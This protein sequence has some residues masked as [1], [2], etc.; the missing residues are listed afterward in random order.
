MTTEKATG[1]FTISNTTAS[2]IL[3]FTSSASFARARNG[4]LDQD[5]Y[6]REFNGTGQAY[7]DVGYD[8]SLVGM[9]G[10]QYTPQRLLPADQLFQIGGPTTVRGYKVDALGGDDGVYVNGEVHPRL[11]SLVQGLDVFSFFDR[12]TVFNVSPTV[13]SLE[14]I[15]YGWNYDFKK[16]ASAQFSMAF[17]LKNQIPGPSPYV[18]YVRLIWHAL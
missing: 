9:F 1:G 13:K 2:H 14:S 15:G 7:F 3:T 4:I 18:I 8:F 12:G 6:I 16:L 11:D 10:A 17:P 5:R